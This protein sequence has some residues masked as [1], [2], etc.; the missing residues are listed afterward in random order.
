MHLNR[1]SLFAAC[2]VLL[3]AVLFLIVLLRPS[4][5]SA[6]RTLVERFGGELK[7]VSLLAPD[8]SSTIAAAYGAYAA[9][10]LLAQWEADPEHAPGRL[11]SSPYPD[12]IVVKAVTQQGES[13]VV[14]GDIVMMSSAGEE[15]RVPVIFQLAPSGS[16]YT[17]VAYQEQ[18]STVSR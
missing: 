16:G 17:I 7:Q 14:S 11:T 6:A 18:A 3:V 10:E 12:H 2:A 15:D 1:Y 9:P 5:E 8:A 4:G 13:Y